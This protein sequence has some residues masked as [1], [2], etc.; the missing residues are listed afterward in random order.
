MQ[1]GKEIK[2]YQALSI[3]SG[4]LLEPKEHLTIFITLGYDPVTGHTIIQ[5]KTISA[6]RIYLGFTCNFFPDGETIENVLK[7]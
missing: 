5:S 6:I 2:A 4:T 7:V 1:G 3:T